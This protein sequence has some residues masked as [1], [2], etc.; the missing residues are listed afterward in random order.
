MSIAHGR[1]R[2]RLPARP[3]SIGLL[4]RAVVEFASDCGATESQRESIAVA[5]SEVL[6]NVVKHAYV[7]RDT[8]AAAVAGAHPDA[9]VAD[10]DHQRTL[11]H[12]GLHC[13]TA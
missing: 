10:H 11:T 5:V 3:Q 1:L 2:E 12:E 8:P 13:D 6:S 7:G 4:R 9:L